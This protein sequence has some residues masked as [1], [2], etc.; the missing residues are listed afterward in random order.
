MEFSKILRS[1]AK[2]SL[3]D[4]VTFFRS[5]DGSLFL[6]YNNKLSKIAS[7]S[8]LAQ[9]SEIFQILKR[10]RYLG[11]I[12][13]LMTKFKRKDII[14]I[15]Q[16]LYQRSFITIQ[17]QTDREFSRRS[18]LTPRFFLLNPM[19]DKKSPL[20]DSQILL[21]GDGFLADRLIMTL[22]K[23][24]VKF[25]QIKSLGRLLKPTKKTAGKSIAEN[26]KVIS[27]TSSL[28]I[29]PSFR[30]IFDK[31]DLI[32]VVED[33]QNIAL[34]DFVNKICFE[35]KKSW[36]RMSFDDDVGYLGPL[37]VPGRTSCFNCCELRLVTNSPNY[38]YELWRNKDAIPKTKLQVPEIFADILSAICTREILRYLSGNEEPETIDNLIVFD[39]HVLNYTKHKV[40]RHPNC[41]YCNAVVLPK[42]L[43]SR[44]LHGY[45]NISRQT[46]VPKRNFDSSVRPTEN[47]LV[48]RL[49]KLIDIR[50]G[51]IQET[52]KIFIDNQLGINSHYFLYARCSKPLRIGLNGK[53]AKL[54]ELGNSLV[55][56]SPAGSGLSPNEAEIRTLMEAVERYS[57]MVADESRFIW[58]TYND[59]E[60]MAIN[61]QDLGL[62][63]DETYD[64][65][66]RISRYSPDEEIPWIKGQDLYSGKP[67]LIAADF[68]HYPAIRP[69]PIVLESS[70]GASAHTDIVQAILNGLYELIERDAFLTMWLNKIPMPILDIRT[71]PNDFDESIRMIREYDMSVKLFDLTNDSRVPTAMAVCYN[72]N[73]DKY[74]AVEVG[75]ATHVEPEKAVQKALF[76]ME[77]GLIHN[78]EEDERKIL[79]E[80]QIAAIYEHAIYYLNPR[81]RKYWE[82]MISSKQASKLSRF[83]GKVL[84]DQNAVLM[85]IVKHLHTLGRRV[86]YVDITPPDIRSLGLVAVKVFVTGFQPMYSGNIVRLNMERLHQSA[87]YVLK[88]IGAARLGTELNSAPHP[89]A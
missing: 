3:A 16:A 18:K 46:I 40:L 59:I 13:K 47:E 19:E 41:I 42:K 54:V 66:K 37:V 87:E 69:K 64:K 50:T 52:K 35:K 24:N 71:L 45:L 84:K 62:Y 6:K 61:P 53:L 32:I 36:I 56:P 4:G 51:V 27:E 89:L 10:P 39:T 14:D 78:L 75:T 60:K 85:E 26:K 70:N 79:E 74:P 57:N 11:E 81:K 67:V 8:E 63:L 88:N 21:I 72:N 23:M 83:A 25:N 49:R 1:D 29:S 7:S 38:E 68:V 76:E 43:H 65:V 86:V 82:F 73:P 20:V 30:P 2:I 58:S 22:K 55:Y 9:Q 31:S 5:D 12:V 48:E 15:L 34:F 44:S 28:S 33:Y 77:T 80:D 17:K